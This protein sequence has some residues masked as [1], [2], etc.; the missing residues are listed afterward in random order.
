M[1]VPLGVRDQL[2]RW[3]HTLPSSGHPGVART[4]RS[5]RG[6]YWWPTLARDVR[7]YVSSCSVCAQ[8]KA[9]RHLP[10]GKLQPLPVPQRPWSHLSVDF[11]TD[12]PP[13][14]GALQSW[15][16]WIGFQ[17]PAVSS[18]C[19]VSLRPCRL[20]WLSTQNLPLCVPC[21]KLGPQCVGPF[22]VLRRINEVCYRLQLPSYYRI[23]PSFHVSLL[24]PV[25]A[26][27]L[28]E[29]EVPEVP[30]PPSGHR[31]YPAYSI[32]AILDSRRRVRGLQYLVYWEGYGPEERCWVPAE[33]VLDPSMLKDFH[34][35]RPDRPAPRPPGR[36]RGRCRRAAGAAITKG[37]TTT[38]LSLRWALLRD[39]LPIC[40]W[41][42]AGAYVQL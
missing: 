17:S 30:P 42:T 39:A 27:P 10:R 31:G 13:F 33:D 26:G 34:R 19:P 15:W 1:Y 40:S 32:R 14:R 28:Q 11:L 6:K 29:D 2:I 37:H 38:G 21:R 23:N 18:R 20:V 25:V 35:L 36:P 24:R 8:S 22:K 4:V 3:A 12:L 9:P 7:F 41:P 5:L 16:L